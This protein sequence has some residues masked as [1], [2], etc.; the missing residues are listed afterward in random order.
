MRFAGLGSRLRAS[1][2]TEVLGLPGLG[3][4]SL[5]T[6]VS[7]PPGWGESSSCGPRGPGPL[8]GLA[9]AW[10]GAVLGARVALCVR[11]S[12]PG[13]C[14]GYAVWTPG[15]SSHRRRPGCC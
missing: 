13:R 11:V 14:L 12:Q 10:L 7:W 4:G 5:R 15:R 9:A 1:L 2:G 3:W 8:W 6:G